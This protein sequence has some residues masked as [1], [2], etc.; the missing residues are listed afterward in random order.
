MVLFLCSAVL[1][2]VCGERRGLPWRRQDA[3]LQQL[4]TGSQVSPRI[5]QRGGAEAGTVV[6]ICGGF[7]HGTRGPNLSDSLCRRAFIQEINL[8][9]TYGTDLNNLQGFLEMKHDWKMKILVTKIG[10]A[11]R[12]VALFW[13]IAVTL[14]NCTDYICSCP[15]SGRVDP[16]HISKEIISGSVT[17]SWRTF[18]AWG[19]S[20][21]INSPISFF[22]SF[23]WLYLCW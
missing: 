4:W 15:F 13:H 19:W 10:A 8:S 7:K 11:W 17:F 6:S 3:D 9:V 5:P 14:R 22:K 16:T 21:L 18:R 12:T 2:A 20:S 1:W 23:F